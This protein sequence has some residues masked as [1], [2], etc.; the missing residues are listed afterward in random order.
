MDPDPTLFYGSFK[1][2]TKNKLI[3]YACFAFLFRPDGTFT[4][5]FK[6]I[7]LVQSQQTEEI[8]VFLDLFA[9]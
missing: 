6:D 5:I 1:M 7:R 3:F 9:C 2:P 4:S 8:K